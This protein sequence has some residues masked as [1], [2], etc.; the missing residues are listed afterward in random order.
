VRVQDTVTFRIGTASCGVASGAA[1][2]A[3]ALRDEVRRLG[4]DAVVEEV[5]C[6]GDCYA[7]PLVDV[8]LPAGGE[9]SYGHLTPEAA[10]R[11]VCE[12]ARSRGVLRKA[13][14]LVRRGWERITADHA[15]V[16]LED[17][18]LV[19]RRSDGAPSERPRVVLNRCGAA[20][21]ADAP[22]YRALA[23]VL[24]KAAGVPPEKVIE[25]VTASGLRG[26]GGAGF[27]T[28]RKWS[29][30]REA[31]GEP[32]YIICNADEGD[33]GAFMDRAVLESDP[34]A[35]LEGLAIAAYAVGAREA[36][37]YV[38][39]E[40][41]LAVKR[42][43]GAIRA[44]EAR[45]LIGG[46]ASAGGGVDVRI[47]VFRSAGAFVCG[48]ETALIASICGRRGT[49][50]VRPPYPSERGYR[51]R[52]T[53][54]NNVETL[55]CVPWILTHGPEAFA[56][57]GTQ[58]S[59]GTKVFALAGAVE[60]GGLVEVPMGASLRE[61]VMDVGGGV[62]GGGALKAV[63]IGG[64]SG[65]CLPERILETP[66]DY[67]ALAG[68]GTIMG[69]GGL[70]VLDD[71][72]CMVDFARFFAPFTAGESCGKC[73]FCRVGSKRLVEILEKLCA[74]KGEEDDLEKLEEIGRLM[75]DAAFCG[76]GKT[77]PNPIL[78]SLRYFREEYEAHIRGVCPAK[79]CKA[80]TTYRVTDKCIGCTLCAQ[81]CP[82][83]ATTPKPYERHEID[84]EKCIRCGMCR[85]ACP[86]DAIEV[87]SP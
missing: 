66:V 86:E 26:R 85:I 76:L 24:D 39:A 60:R 48:E 54:V 83:Q 57:L 3:D 10:R 14:A 29:I 41:P 11:L 4:A 28:G 67:E 44:A 12:H 8:L 33:P 1:A 16:E 9:I 65:G 42:I 23:L 75:K 7:E 69:S 5:G 77:A 55:A 27:P 61:I 17:L 31:E 53:L 32:K 87:T 6:C 35:V 52:P 25:T 34:H 73:T 40:Y 20:N 81:N 36:V 80:L 84:P 47:T 13:A 21:P 82:V 37:I 78:T 68:T 74:G 51:D 58:G 64:P 38:R 62:P 59:K 50:S 70:V 63:Q 18:R 45:G 2:V 49:T 19:G 22:P 56:A 46:G 71:T 15:W 79:T 30:V 43:T 72:T